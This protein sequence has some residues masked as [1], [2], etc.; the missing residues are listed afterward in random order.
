[1]GDMKKDLPSL[2]AVALALGLA[3]PASASIIVM[4]EPPSRLLEK[5]QSNLRWTCFNRLSVNAWRLAGCYQQEGASYGALAEVLRKYTDRLMAIEGVVMVA[6]GKD[7]VGHDCIIVG[8]KAAE[9]LDKIP[10]MIE[11]VPVHATVIGEVL[12]RS[13]G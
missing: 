2:F 7:E 8:V 5:G 6:Q 4:F 10:K 3:F 12:P 11:G 13:S 9:Y 1:M